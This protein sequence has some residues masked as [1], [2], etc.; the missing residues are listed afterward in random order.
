MPLNASHYILHRKR[1]SSDCSLPNDEH[2]GIQK[3]LNS[4]WPNHT[5]G[6][7]V[8]ENMS[9]DRI[10]AKAVIYRLD[11]S[12]RLCEINVW[13]MSYG[14]Y[15][16]LMSIRSCIINIYEVLWTLYGFIFYW[17][18]FCLT[19]LCLVPIQ[20]IAR[21]CDVIFALQIQCAHSNFWI[22]VTVAW[23]HI[24]H[25]NT[26]YTRN[27]ITILWILLV[28]GDSWIIWWHW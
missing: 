23:N 15:T 3:K 2:Y 8:N 1:S 14:I 6:K 5:L 9:N 13:R 19:S 7:C 4:V 20:T 21:W 27:A 11:G 17:I 16:L 28:G 24:Q 10:Y 22:I 26:I 12:H 18:F 25:Y